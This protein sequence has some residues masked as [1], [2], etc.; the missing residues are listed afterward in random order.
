MSDMLTGRRPEIGTE[1]ADFELPD[2][3]GKN[4]RLSELLNGGPV[5]LL[6]YPTDFGMLCSIE[7]GAI[8]DNLHRFEEMGIQVVGLSTNTT[9]S[10]AAWKGNMRIQF[11]LLS[12]VKGIVALRLGMMCPE[13]SWLKGRT[14][15]AAL[16]IDKERRITMAWV[17]PDTH[18]V[19]EVDELLQECRRALGL[20]IP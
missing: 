12:D 9:Y 8:R 4:V 3:T 5:L 13:D 17:P 11:P 6:F 14:C 1:V 2:D 10:H 18:Q 19:P 16:L 15:R 7:M 20:T